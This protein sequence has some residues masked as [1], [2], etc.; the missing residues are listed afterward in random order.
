MGLIQATLARWPRRRR[1]LPLQ[2]SPV[3]Q[4]RARAT[5]PS[6]FLPCLGGT[7][8]DM[9]TTPRHAYALAP[10]LQTLDPMPTAR[11]LPSLALFCAPA[12]F[13]QSC[14][15]S[16]EPR[17]LAPF[18]DLIRRNRSPMEQDAATRSIIEPSCTD[19][20]HPSCTGAPPAILRASTP[21]PVSTSASSSRTPPS[22]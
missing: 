4:A 22:F 16:L 18:I 3:H 15:C 7:V 19:L 11:L 5:P 6:F 1:T 8:P 2:P 17:A 21:P 12:S 20:R 14:H 10:H 9:P 13:Q